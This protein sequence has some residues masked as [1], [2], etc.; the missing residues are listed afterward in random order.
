MTDTRLKRRTIGMLEKR[1]HEA[2]L[3]EVEDPRDCRGRRWKLSTLL[4]TTILG[5]VAGCKGLG[6]GRQGH[7]PAGGSPA[8][9]IARFRHVAMPQFEQVTA[10]PL[11]GVN[12]PAARRDTE[13]PRWA[14]SGGLASVGA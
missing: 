5:L 13:P 6:S 14:R 11:R 2:R 7:N 4:S 9:S 10:R 12:G 8:M 1:L 3:D